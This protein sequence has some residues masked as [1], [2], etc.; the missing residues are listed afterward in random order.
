LSSQTKLPEFRELLDSQPGQ[1]LSLQIKNLENSHW[2]RV[3]RN[4]K[5]KRLRSYISLCQQKRLKSCLRTL[6]L[7]FSY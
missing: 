7:L 2:R 3:F 1:L 4:R 5:K 6:A